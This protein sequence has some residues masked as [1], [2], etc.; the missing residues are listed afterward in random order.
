MV[1][2]FLASGHRDSELPAAF[3]SGRGEPGDMEVAAVADLIDRRGGRAW[4]VARNLKPMRLAA[5][6]LQKADPPPGLYDDLLAAG[7][8]YLA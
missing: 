7:A 6:R 8:R 3:H 5:E 1:T 2:V 4:A